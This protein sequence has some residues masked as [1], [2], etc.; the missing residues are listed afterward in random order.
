MPAPPPPP[1]PSDADLR[2]LLH[3]SAGDGRIWLAGQRML[4]V[5]TA[6][7][8]ALRG[9]LM[10]TIG[11]EQTRRLLMRAGYAPGERDAALPRRGPGPASGYRLLAAGPRLPMRQRSR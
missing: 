11:R 7:L 5:H 9:E 10:R 8:G 1:F 4:L 3:F 2:R 6:A